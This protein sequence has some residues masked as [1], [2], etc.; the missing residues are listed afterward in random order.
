MV[1][2]RNKFEESWNILLIYQ[3]DSVGRKSIFAAMAFRQ[4]STPVILNAFDLGGYTTL[5][6]NQLF[7]QQSG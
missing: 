2:T 7:L 6:N 5:T 1:S 3:K 4:I